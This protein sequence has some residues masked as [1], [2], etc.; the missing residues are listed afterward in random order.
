MFITSG[1]IQCVIRTVLVK[2][3]V[4]G[5]EVTVGSLCA[6]YPNTNLGRTTE[7]YSDSSTYRRYTNNCI[8]RS[9]QVT[10][11]SEA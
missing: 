11:L 5:P 2:H 10:A 9:K 8:Y 4:R 7:L 6:W 3:P 1:H